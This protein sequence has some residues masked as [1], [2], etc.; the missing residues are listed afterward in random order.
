MNLKTKINIFKVFNISDNFKTEYENRLSDFID[1][2]TLGVLPISTNLLS[3]NIRELVEMV[4]IEEL[5][6]YHWMN[7]NYIDKKT[8]EKEYTYKDQFGRTSE[9]QLS[10]RDKCQV[11]CSKIKRKDEILKFT[12]KFLR[13]KILFK[14]EKDNKKQTRNQLDLKNIFNEEMLNNDKDLIDRFYS[15]D[16]S[17]KDLM[18]LKENK[19]V[20]KML[21][22]HFLKRYIIDA[23]ENILFFNQEKMF[24]E[25]INVT[26]LIKIFYCNQ[27]KKAL[28][29]QD[30]INTFE[31]FA[32]YFIDNI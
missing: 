30:V 17:K 1:G 26:S 23:I 11:I 7:R 9:L 15:Y 27:Q 29:L 2:D 14:Y 21:I 8:V 31:L 20:Y 28:V 5:Q 25:E 13:K 19:K 18:I 4:E 10:F 22:D 3:R 12:F 32:N 6:F 16:V 24:K